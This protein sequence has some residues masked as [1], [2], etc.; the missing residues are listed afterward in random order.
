MASWSENDRAEFARLLTKFTQPLQAV[1]V[2]VT[3]PYKPSRNRHRG[4]K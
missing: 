1:G 3:S 4:G 2:L